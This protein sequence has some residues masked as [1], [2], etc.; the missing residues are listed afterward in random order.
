MKRLAIIPARGGSVRIPQKNIR[1]FLGKSMILRAI[2]TAMAAEIFDKIVVSTDCPEVESAAWAASHAAMGEVPA[3]TH[4]PGRFGIHHRPRC[5]GSMGTQEVAAMVLRD[6]HFFDAA[7]VIY[8]CTPLLQPEDLRNGWDQLLR[9]HARYAF[10]VQKSPLADA[11]AY[12]WGWRGA[13]LAGLPLIDVYTVMV[14]LPSERVCDINTPEDWAR[15]EAM[16]K[17]LR[18]AEPA[19]TEPTF[20]MGQHV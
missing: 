16:Y 6:E 19:R 15:A 14:P 11:G 5:D 2:A 12:Y 13:F 1:P 20:Q 4:L 8:P 9:Q 17:A 7:C 3:R 10:S 18:C